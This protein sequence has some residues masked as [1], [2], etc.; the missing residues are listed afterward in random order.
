MIRIFGQKV[1]SMKKFVLVLLILTISQNLFA[2][3]IHSKIKTAVENR[4]YQTAISELQTL[5]RTD[6]KLFTLN[7]Y[8]YLLARMAKKQGDFAIAMANYQAVV[9]RKSVLREYALYHLAE[10]ARSTGNLALERIYLQ[11]ITA[12]PPESLL[13]NSA[14]ARLA[15]NYFESKDFSMAISLLQNLSTPSHNAASV[16]T[17]PVTVISNIFGKLTGN[18][19]KTRENLAFLG[20]AFLQNGKT[21]EAREVFTK[22]VNNLP[23]LAQPDDYALTGVRGLDELDGGKDN[24]G[25][26]RPIF[27][28][29]NICAAL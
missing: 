26:M 14:D 3:D 5:Q 19:A 20:Q 8:D 7:N 16:L 6:K 4:E 25:K 9:N 23:N 27:L 11:Q 15:R 21:N 13:K 24:F 22:L 12:S 29:P 17:S 2:Q 28:T 1:I 10:I 18:D